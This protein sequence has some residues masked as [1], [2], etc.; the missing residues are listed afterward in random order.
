M[1]KR[2]LTL[3][4]IM[5]VIALITIIGGVLGYNMKGSLEKGK[6][7]RTEQSIKQIEDI[8]LL[9]Y[10]KGEGS[11]E[12][13]ADNAKEVIAR[14]GLAKDPAELL[15]DGWGEDI[16]IKPLKTEDGFKVYSKRYKEY[17]KR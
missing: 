17:K 16:V 14:S 3:L 7:F 10:A 1:K 13:I 15:K 5:I 2:F 4:E 11:L 6:A 12:E 8:L 9:E